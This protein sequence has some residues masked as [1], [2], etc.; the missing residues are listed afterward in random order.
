MRR[1]AIIF[2]VTC[3]GCSPGRWTVN[4][5]RGRSFLIKDRLPVTLVVD[6]GPGGKPTFQETVRASHGS[7]PK[8]VVS[9][10]F[11]IKSGAV[12]CD[13]REVAEIDGVPID[14]QRGRWWMVEVNGS[15]NVSPHRTRVKRG[16]LIRWSYGPSELR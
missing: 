16:D 9:V 6:F 11:P 8:D 3:L 14:P 2:A 7:T 13:T 12:C 10:F 4:D 5:E 1:L 15:R